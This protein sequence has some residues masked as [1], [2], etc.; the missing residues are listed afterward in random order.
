M[1]VAF[2]LGAGGF[3]GGHVARHYRARGW[4]VVTIGPG[5]QDETS[6]L[7]LAWRLPHAEFAR[8]LAAEKPRLCVNA[9]GSAS[10]P[11]SVAEPLADFRANTALNAALLDDL[12]RHS[13]AT[14]F[15]H[16]SS[17]AVYGNPAALPID[18]TAALAPISPYGWHKRLSEMVL[19]EY[20]ALYGL[21]TASLRIFS[22]Y[23]AALRRQV[24]WDLAA[25]AANLTSGVLSLQGASEDS[26][27]FIHGADVAAAVDCIAERGALAG[28]CY[29][30][31]NGDEVSIAGLARRVLRACG[32]EA[33][34][35]FD[36]VRRPGNP[37]RWHADIGRLSALGFTPRVDFGQGVQEVV[38]RAKKSRD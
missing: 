17:A 7:H 36:N 29:N 8:L 20:A 6:D 19:E 28:E 30:T 5:D 4:R 32:R 18:E 9:A 34:I 35:R 2:V 10:V 37:S 33:E 24:V 21:K 38:A 27:D 11:T 13:P 25:R 14:I 3:L 12:R 1:S 23:G 31:A 16:F 22:A 15:L 26:R